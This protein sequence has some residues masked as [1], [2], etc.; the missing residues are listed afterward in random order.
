MRKTALWLAAALLLATIALA[1]AK[2]P[3]AFVMK[4][5][6]G[7]RAT[8]IV[9]GTEFTITKDSPFAEHNRKFFFFETEENK[10][11]FDADPAKYAAPPK[12]PVAPPAAPPKDEPPAGK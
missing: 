1:E 9:S 5:A 12:K 7:S 4:P 8:D 6:I 2:A 3:V 11:A 10:R